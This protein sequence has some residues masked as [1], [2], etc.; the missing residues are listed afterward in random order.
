MLETF[1]RLSLD[2]N[3]ETD[4]NSDW[5]SH[6][7]LFCL[8]PYWG[9]CTFDD[10]KEINLHLSCIYLGI[11]N[12]EFKKKNDHLNVFWLTQKRNRNII[13]RSLQD[14]ILTQY[15]EFKNERVNSHTYSL[16]SNTC[17]YFVTNSELQ[18]I[19]LS[20]KCFGK[21]WMYVAVFSN[22]IAI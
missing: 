3:D 5:M 22:Q 18:K 10:L 14:I 16:T 21:N 12:K 1:F 15:F 20:Y 13:L 8:A 11:F 17:R 2:S 7:F 19:Q 4:V 9:H 6:T